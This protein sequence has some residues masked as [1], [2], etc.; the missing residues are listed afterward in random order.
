MALGSTQ[1]LVK[2]STRNI[3]GGKL[4]GAWGW[5]PHNLYVPNVMKS[6]SLNLLE[7]SGPHQAFYGTPL[8]LPLP[9]LLKCLNVLNV[10]WN[11]KV[12]NKIHFHCPN[13]QTGSPLLSNRFKL[14]KHQ[15]RDWGCHSETS[16]KTYAFFW[17]I[18][19]RLNFICR[20]FGTLCLFH[21]Y[22]RIGMWND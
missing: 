8:P 20:R 4:A 7:P 19:R 10:Q 15:L 16:Q 9:L 17:V 22:R 11:N 21:L 12:Y 3:P 14:E 18:P 13:I 5:R 1:P 6:G 2:I